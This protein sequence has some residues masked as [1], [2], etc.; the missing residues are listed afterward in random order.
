MMALVFVRIFGAPLNTDLVG[1]NFFVRLNLCAAEKD[2]SS[3]IAFMRRGRSV[4]SSLSLWGLKDSMMDLSSAA[5]SSVPV[6]YDSKSYKS[7]LT[8]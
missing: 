8:F 6:S 4:F 3:P 7:S 1:A 5:C 2:A